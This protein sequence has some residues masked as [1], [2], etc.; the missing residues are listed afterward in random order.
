MLDFSR[1]EKGNSRIQGEADEI[2]VRLYFLKFLGSIE[3]DL[4]CLIR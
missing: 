2:S 4:V 3:R 1:Q